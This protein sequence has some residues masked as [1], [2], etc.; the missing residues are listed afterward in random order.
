MLVSGYRYIIEPDEMAI[1][2]LAPA[3]GGHNS[4]WAA[5]SFQSVTLTLVPG[6]RH[7]VAFSPRRGKRVF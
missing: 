2:I 7:R 6:E 4:A 1:D 5:E 3:F